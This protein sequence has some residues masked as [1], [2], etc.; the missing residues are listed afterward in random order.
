MIKISAIMMLFIKLS[1]TFAQSGG[2][3]FTIYNAHK[4]RCLGDNLRELFP[5]NPQSPRQQFRWT[6]ENRIFNV[7]QKKCLGTGSK[8]EGNKLQWYICDAN[9]DLQ[10]WEC[11]S[12]SLFGLKNES[13]YL[14]LQG[15]SHLLTLSKDPGDKGRWTIHG[16]TDDNVCSSPYEEMYSIKGNALGQ[17]CHFPFHFKNKWYTECTTEGRSSNHLWCAIEREYEPNQLWGYCPTQQMGSDFWRKSPLTDVYYQ[18]N[19]GSALTW[20]QARKSCQQQGGDLLSITE[21]H[22]QTFISGLTDNTGPVLWTGLN[23]L[24]ASS[25][26]HWVNGQPLRYLRWLSGQPSSTPSHSCGVLSQLHGSEWSTA[27]CSERHGYICQTGLPTPTV[28]AAVHSGFCHSP[29]IPYSGH[30]YF[31][32]RT[33][34]T[35]LEARDSCRRK[36]GDLLSILSVEEQSFIISQLGYSKTDELW[37]GFN[38]LKTSM[39]FE[40]S[41]HSSVTF[42]LWD[43]KEP[44]HY[45]GLK[46]DCVLMRGEEGK[47][48]DHICQN[49][50][51]YICKKN[52]YSDSSTLVTSPGCKPGWMRFGYYCYLTGSETKTFEEA[53]QMCEKTGSYLADI[54][55]RFENAFLISLIGD[56]PEMHFWIGLSNQKNQDS[57]EWTNT[58]KV[59]FTHF[60]NDLPGGK[61]GCV[62][63]RTGILAGLWDVLKCTNQEKYI[64]KQKAEG[65]ITTPAP[66]TTQALGC[67]EG[68]YPLTN[69]DHCFKLYKVE[70]AQRKTWSEARDFCRETGGDLLSLHST[71]EIP[72]YLRTSYPLEAWIGY[73]IQDP[74]VGYTWSDGSASS[75]SSWSQGEPSNI[76]SEKCVKMHFIAMYYTNWKEKEQWIGVHCEDREHWYCE[77]Q[78]GVT[79]KEV[80]IPHKTYNKTDDGWII[81]KNNQYYFCADPFNHMAKGRS[82]CKHRHGDLV[83]INDEE[84]R[85]FVWHQMKERYRNFYI[86]MYIDLDKSLSWMDGSPVLFQAWA[87]NQ[88]AFLNNDEHCV[89]MT[90]SQGLWQSVNCGDGAGFV[91]KRSGSVP[92][93]AAAAPTEPPKGG[94][95]P[96]WVKFQEKCYKIGLDLKT[97]TEARSYCRQ[98]G[99]NLASITSTIQQ[100]FLT[101]RMGDANMPDLW[102]GLNNL[103][104][105]RLRWTD[106]SA[107]WHTEFAASEGGNI[108]WDYS[109]DEYLKSTK[110]QIC[111]VMGGVQRPN[112]GKWVT[113]NCND[114]SGYICSQAVDHFIEPS[115]TEV[116]KTFIRFG[117][118]YYMLV[119]TN[120]T[121]QEAELYC[122]AEGA[123]LASIRDAF[124]E[125]YI[126][127]QTYKLR[128]P[129]WIGLNSLETD[130]YFHWIDKWE[131][132]MVRWGSNEPKK[133]RPCVYVDVG[134]T[135]KSAQCN[136]TLYSVCKKS[137]DIAPTPPAHYLGVCP[138]QTEEEPTMTWLPFKGNC[139]AF[140][141]RS[142]P[143]NTASQICMSRGTNL[144]S[145]LDPMEENFLDTY[146]KFFGDDYRH[147]WMGLFK[148]HAGQ[149]LW[150]DKSV[151]SYFKLR[152]MIAD[153]E[154]LHL[155]IHESTLDCASFAASGTW[156]KQHCEDHAPFICKT[157][158]VILPPTKMANTGKDEPHRA[159]TGVS[160][161]VVIVVVCALAG[162]AYVYHRCSR[163]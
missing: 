12:D 3:S 119:Q 103:V 90:H 97:W 39:L 51:G 43:T 24:D 148:N 36:G 74:S 60:N 84:E 141:K 80:N 25:G 26:W 112:L 99:G 31:L 125:A 89:K 16:T 56:R 8:S 158:K 95:A 162:M 9:N 75:Y 136:Q 117:N 59:L 132:N 163:R 92:I 157:A 101:S 128:Q 110:P 126:D 135:W 49:K 1:L 83:V 134:G 76:N 11:Q 91:C 139:Y 159:F 98:L 160:A 27:V 18:L 40:W 146:I 116:S 152:Q 15:D 106:G 30:C 7:E 149:W 68:W 20:Y 115:S 65:V 10:K 86:G 155:R 50:Y 34:T 104:E 93:N 69:R 96:D 53:K 114:T 124:T 48:A 57:F 127:L 62:A 111:V 37:I 107:V 21:P 161:V 137:A 73:S 5:C 144:V 77:I 123:K 64:C 52:T 38:D 2:T 100:T 142:V 14:S 85:L 54:T 113:K 150:V 72:K 138:N 6:S 140:V 63:M 154:F 29:W 33:T 88:P 47:W 131:L 156:Q 61:Q 28:P 4:N 151:L 46:E 66:P 67:S 153:H 143:W 55:D 129:L 45:A 121:W 32:N 108:K 105:D 78:K 133:D 145:I 87:Q 102:V 118:S 130:G 58:E 94:C 44:S 122:E 70:K 17:P 120:L 71:D 19:E 41:D 23:N 109:R 42:A 82:F 79:P 35:W 147:F 22:E 13:L 81:F